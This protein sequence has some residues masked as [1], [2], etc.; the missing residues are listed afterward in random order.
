MSVDDSASSDTDQRAA[1]DT[2]LEPLSANEV[3]TLLSIS[4]LQALS[5]LSNA[6]F[7]MPASTLYSAHVLPSRPAYIPKDRRETVVVAR[8]E[9]KKLAKWMKE[10]SK[11]KLVSIKESKG[12]AT[13]TGYVA[14]TRPPLARTSVHC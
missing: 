6:E 9:W 8:S 12:E 2:A 3:S 13:V 14:L 7:P 11:E 1:A 4:L 5:T 10:A